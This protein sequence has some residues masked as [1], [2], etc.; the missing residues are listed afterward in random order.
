MAII[1]G[2]EAFLRT[3]ETQK[4]RDQ[5]TKQHGEIETFVFDGGSSQAAEV[6]DECRSFGLMATHKLIIVDNAAELVKE[7][8]RPLF[9][10]YAEQPVQSATLVLRGDKW[11][12]GKLD[13]LVEK[14]GVV[15]A[16]KEP[17]ADDAVAWVITHA[18]KQ[19]NAVFDK[20]TAHTLVQRV[21]PALGKLDTEI[22]KLAAAAGV[23]ESGAANPITKQLIAQFVGVS[24]EE[25][26]WNIQ[27]TLLTGNP[28][29]ALQ[30]LRHILDVS[31]QPAPVVMYAMLDLARKLHG[32]TAGMKAG[33]NPFQLAGPLKLWGP[34]KDMILAS[35]RRLN[36]ADTLAFYQAAVEADLRTKSGL[37]E[38]DRNME[39]LTVK[40]CAL[41]R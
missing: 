33:A 37:G 26:A 23:N 34:S 2:P 30:H 13:K 16:C 32:V 31:R 35:A 14:I 9:E 21:G 3:L 12:A 11:F 28:D 10:K 15:I 8:S 1:T 36:P 29:A 5:L 20:E 22:A 39:M 40:L 38:A 7:H 17:S 41:L 25:E 27:K 19:H 24:R 6:L 4:L 18:K